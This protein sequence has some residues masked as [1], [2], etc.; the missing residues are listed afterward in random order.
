MPTAIPDM[1]RFSYISERSA[2]KATS[3]DCSTPKKKV[4][5]KKNEGKKEE[6]KKIKFS[7]F[8]TEKLMTEKKSMDFSSQFN[9]KN[10]GKLQRY[11]QFSIIKL[12][13]NYIPIKKTQE[14][15]KEYGIDKVIMEYMKLLEERAKPNKFRDYEIKINSLKESL[16]DSKTKFYNDD[17]LP[18]DLRKQLLEYSVEKKPVLK[19]P[20]INI[21]EDEEDNKPPTELEDV[22]SQLT[23][24]KGKVKNISLTNIL[25]LE[26]IKF[27]VDIQEKIRGEVETYP[28]FTFF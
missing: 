11:T 21:I 8:S 20:K 2:S 24:Y 12:I 3:L 18:A 4:E 13:T 23:P 19:I 26:T 9:Q 14:L 16:E 17:K 5:V 22:K 6:P 27:Y 15:I 25:L 28:P 7:P 10:R 1:R